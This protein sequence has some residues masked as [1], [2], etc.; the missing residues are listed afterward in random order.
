MVDTRGGAFTV[1]LGVVP[2]LSVIARANLWSPDK[3][4]RSVEMVPTGVALV[5]LPERTAIVLED[6]TWRAAGVGTPVVHGL[7]G[8]AA[9]ADLPQP[10][11]R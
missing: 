8:S 5:E 11:G 7:D 3:V 1:G 2:H 4:H 6:G 9:L 10:A